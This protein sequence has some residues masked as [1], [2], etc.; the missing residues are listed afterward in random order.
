MLVAVDGICEPDG[1][2]GVDNNVVGGVKGSAMI[3]VYKGDGFMGSFGFHV[4]EAGGLAEGALGA[5]DDAIAEVGA[6][7]GHV[8]AFWTANFVPS[9]VGR[10]EELDFG[11]EDSF[12]RSGDGVRGGVGNLVRGD[13]EGIGGWMKDAC[14]VKVR[15]SWVRDEKGKAWGW[16]EEVEERIMVDKKWAGLRRAG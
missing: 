16:A 7:V 1:S 8:I 6:A 15:S 14:F 9:E 12:V 2:V 4:D 10:G 13:E 3:V 5:E 11:D